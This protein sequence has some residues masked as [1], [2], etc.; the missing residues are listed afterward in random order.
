MKLQSLLLIFAICMSAEAAD[1]ISLMKLKA[2]NSCEGCDLSNTDLTDADLTD[3][4][5]TNAD[6]TGA[7]LTDANLTNA[8]LTD[9]ILVSANLTNADLKNLQNLSKAKLC[10]TTLPWGVD[11]SGC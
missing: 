1:D 6:L 9:A 7:N 2:T 3:A 8:D 4:N 11:N 5:L 10:K